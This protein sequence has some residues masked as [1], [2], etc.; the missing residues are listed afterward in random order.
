MSKE[1]AGKW[2]WTIKIRHLVTRGCQWGI[3]LVR[4]ELKRT[5][6]SIN[7]IKLEISQIR[8]KISS[9][10]PFLCSLANLKKAWN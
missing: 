4:K 5:T 6:L 7:R 2:G 8:K 3:S 1:A 10:K 9:Y